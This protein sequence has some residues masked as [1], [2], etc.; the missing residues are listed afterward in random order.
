MKKYPS[1]LG[2]TERGKKE[3]RQRD[4]DIIIGFAYKL[5]P[6]SLEI[7]GSLAVEGTAIGAV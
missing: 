3:H 4:S 5:K 2:S 6:V 1:I 7:I